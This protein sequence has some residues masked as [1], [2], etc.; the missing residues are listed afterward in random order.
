MRNWAAALIANSNYLKLK[1]RSKEEIEAVEDVKIVGEQIF[2]EASRMEAYDRA[3]P[4]P[5]P[6]SPSTQRRAGNS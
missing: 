3:N 6:I 5:R 1:V 4:D 2:A